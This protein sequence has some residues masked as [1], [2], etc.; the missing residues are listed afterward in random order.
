MC[1]LSEAFP[2]DE[3]RISSAAP[4]K[5]DRLST[6]LNYQ[7]SQEPIISVYQQRYPQRLT[8]QDCTTKSS[9]QMTKHIVAGDATTIS[10][11][12]PTNLSC[13]SPH[14]CVQAD[15]LGNGHER[16]LQM[17]VACVDVPVA[18]NRSI[19]CKMDGPACCKKLGSDCK[20]AVKH[21]AAYLAAVRSE[22]LIAEGARRTR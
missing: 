3:M 14:E 10:H 12:Q 11:T 2:V 1:K 16:R 18:A 13:Q 8:W 22:G 17:Y 5:V 20:A 9:A 21:F 6:S 19:Y 4:P 15:C 7:N